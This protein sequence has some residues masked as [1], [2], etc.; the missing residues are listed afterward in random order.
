MVHF[1]VVLPSRNRVELCAEALASVVQQSHTG[2]S[3]V[4]VD[5]GST[6]EAWAGYVDLVAR[7]GPEVRLISLP[8]RPAGHGPAFARNEGVATDDGAYIAFLDD[9]DSWTDPEHL[10][11]AAAIIRA[12][13][14]EERPADLIL[15]RQQAWRRGQPQSQAV[16]LDPLVGVLERAG[17]RPTV[18]GAVAVDVRDLMRVDGF[19]H[20]NTLIVARELFEAV[21]GFD[22]SLRYE[23]DRDLYLRLI[24]RARSIWFVPQ[25]VARHN[26]PDPKGGSVSS[27]V[28]R[29][30]KL[31]FQQRLL[32]K[33][34]LFSRHGEIRA[35]ARRH[36]T[37]V[38]KHIAET[39][40]A[41]GRHRLAWHYAA[42][43]LGAAPSL[44]W[45]ARTGVMALRALGGD[46]A[47]GGGEGQA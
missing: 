43:A 26:I 30:Q 40:R 5:D 1:T 29:L 31:L 33:A 20:L 14:A 7:A 24:D 9:D 18:H 47:T 41:E 38:L 42:E 21:G 17:R 23:E 45:A 35:H 16:W 11:R 10:A 25:V 36:K 3:V 6:P 15:A 39:L 44:K 46:R 37:Y 2:R 19:A 4:L 32:E 22:E 8:R 34:T 27:S 12:A 13:A 28:G